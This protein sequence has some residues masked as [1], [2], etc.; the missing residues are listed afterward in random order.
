MPTQSSAAAATATPS[1]PTLQAVPDAAPEFEVSKAAIRAL[2]AHASKE[3]ENLRSVAIYPDGRMVATDGH[4]MIAYAPDGVDLRSDPGVEPVRIPRDVLERAVKLLPNRKGASATI[5][6]VDG[7]TAEIQVGGVTL[8][9][10][11]STHFPP[12]HTILSTR[13]TEDRSQAAVNG[14]YLADAAKALGGLTESLVSAVKLDCRGLDD[15]SPIVLT[16]SAPKGAGQWMALIMPV[17]V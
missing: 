2:I 14:L 4:R 15:G 12:V 3:R 17:R 1:A 8:R 6:L 7:S 11:A 13:T 16:A 10:G 5:T 9:A